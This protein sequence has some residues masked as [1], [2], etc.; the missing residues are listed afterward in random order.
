MA[1][2][3]LIGSMWTD[4]DEFVD[5]QQKSA[6]LLAKFGGRYLVVGGNPAVVQGD[7]CPRSVVVLEFPDRNAAKAF[8]NDPGYADL[9]LTVPPPPFDM[10][11]VLV[12]G[13]A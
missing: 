11:F 5:Y 1:R 4:L 6:S 2:A 3:Y 7:E 8:Y 13:L 10:R 9:R 12:D